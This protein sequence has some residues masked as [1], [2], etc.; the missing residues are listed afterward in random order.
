M[1]DSSSVKKS[2][3]L[4]SVIIAVATAQFIMPYM[5][6]GVGPLLPAIGSYFNATVVELSLINAVY[7]LSLTIFHLIAGRISDIVGLRRLFLIGLGLFTC[8]SGLLPFSPNIIVFFILRFIQ[9]IGV[10]FMNTSGLS[11]LAN[12]SPRE[13]LGRVLGI[14]STG[15]YLGLSLGPCLAGVMAKFF[16]WAYLFYLMIPIGLIAWL[17]MAY[18]VKKE[19]YNDAEFPFDW[20]G[21]IFYTIGIS[22]LSIGA[23]W[24]LN[25]I[26]AI[27]LLCIGIIFLGI[28]FK[29]E[30][31]KD[32]S[33]LDIKFLIHNHTFLYSILALL[34]NYSSVFG[35]AFYFSLYLQL[36]YGLSVLKTGMI[37]S[38]QPL[39]QVVISPV[40]GRLADI[41]G[42]IKIAIVGMIVCG[43]GLFFATKLDVQSSLA[44]VGYI[45]II[46][47]LG[48]GLFASPN[49][50]AIM[51]S[52]DSKHVNQASG[53]VGTMR[54]F[55]LLL[56]MLIIS[57][58]MSS[59]F[60]EEALTA[61]NISKFIE[62]MNMNLWVFS[63]L[64]IIAIVFSIV[65]LKSRRISSVQEL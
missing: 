9:A 34:I 26:W 54:T 22:T 43:V 24:V 37:L 57:I 62:A 64:N 45:Q 23:I 30:I 53:L 8:I 13:Q 33:I 38:L 39:V 40:A 25:G 18:T 32:H 41:F 19:W 47:G 48:L 63:I 6:S 21:S 10:A 60:G 4:K 20:I 11:I 35:L 15:I 49:T 52:V 1:I 36:G 29:F 16:G 59:Y 58:T 27:I 28:F 12:C 65:S 5:L 42:A 50:T 44:E 7:A 14:T 2:Y 17:L 31:N 3:S 56:S 61:K 55:G 51:S 46:L